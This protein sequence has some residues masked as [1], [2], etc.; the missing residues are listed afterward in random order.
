MA[1]CGAVWQV[2]RKQ[3]VQLQRDCAW[4]ACTD[5][6]AAAKAAVLIGLY[7]SPL[8]Y[9]LLLSVDERPSI[10]ARERT[11]GY[12]Q[13]S[14]YKADLG[15]KNVYKRPATNCLLTALAVATTDAIRGTTTQIKKRA[16]F[17]AFMAAVIWDQPAGRRIHVILSTLSTLSTHEKDGD[18]LE[19]NPN[20]TFHRTP[21]IANWLH[22]VEIWFSIFQHRALNNASFGSVEL[23]KAIHDLTVVYDTGAAPFVWRKRPPLR[24]TI[25]NLHN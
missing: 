22:Q 13:S 21:E 5:P 15:R 12:V 8:Q 23:T 6:E 18:W 7:L 17:Q 14:T 19:A 3:S 25:S 9:A 1:W 16:D 2:L 4:P 10:P 11:R 24:N 20:F